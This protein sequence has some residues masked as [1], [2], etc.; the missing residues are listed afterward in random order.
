MSTTASP[1]D[2]N[3]PRF[4]QAVIAL[5]TG[6]GFVLNQPVLVFVSFAI[7]FVSRAFSPRYAPLTQFYLRFV[8]PR[9]STAIQT[10]DSRAPAFA[11]MLGSLMLGM[12]TIAFLAGLP[13]IG[14]ILSLIVT[15]LAGLA[16]TANI[17]VGC[18]LYQRFLEP[19]RA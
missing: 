2:V 7:L 16:A 8:R 5:L 15:A 4:N 18:I 6:V 13:V 12:G 17:C 10:E 1:I 3:V 14:W 11:Q 19:A 9:F